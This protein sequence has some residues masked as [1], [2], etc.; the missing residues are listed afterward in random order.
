MKKIL[1]TAT[2]LALPVIIVFKKIGGICSLCM[3]ASLS[4]PM[5]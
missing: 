5:L 1:E 2:S 4:V 3:E